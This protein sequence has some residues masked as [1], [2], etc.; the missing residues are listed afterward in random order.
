MKKYIHLKQPK[1]NNT[2][3]T[4]VT[5][6]KNWSSVK[7]WKLKKK[8]YYKNRLLA[9]EIVLPH[10]V[11]NFWEVCFF[12]CHLCHYYDVL[13]PPSENLWPSPHLTCTSSLKITKLLDLLS[14]FVHLFYTI[15]TPSPNYQVWLVSIYFLCF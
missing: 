4:H 12:G 1:H 11:Q 5:M 6:N 15:C 7:I 8:R 14:E 2:Y 9:T 13:S 3:F 10:V